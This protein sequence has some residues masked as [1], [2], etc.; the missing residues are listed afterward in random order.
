MAAEPDFG[1]RCDYKEGV[2]ESVGGRRGSETGVY[3]TELR[4]GVQQAGDGG[5]LCDYD[6]GGFLSEAGWPSAFNS[7]G[8]EEGAVGFSGAEVGGFEAV[9]VLGAGDGHH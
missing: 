5:L 4:H 6:V 7:F 9:Q 8:C 1:R 2:V 3:N